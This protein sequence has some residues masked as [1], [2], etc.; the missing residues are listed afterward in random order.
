M[1][2][3]MIVKANDEYEAGQPPPP[4]LTARI[5]EYSAQMAKQGVVLQGAGLVPSSRGARIQAAGGTLMVM[6]GPFSETKELIA[7]FAIIRADSREQA[8]EFGKDFMRQHIEVLGAGYTG[9]LEVR[10]IFD[11]TDASHPC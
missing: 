8:I 10:Q 3:M 9:Q 5:A 4:A 1:Q 7:G 11:P 2:F 6:D